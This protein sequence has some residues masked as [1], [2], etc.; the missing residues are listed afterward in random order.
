MFPLLLI[1]YSTITKVLQLLIKYNY[2]SN[3]NYEN[4]GLTYF[5]LKSH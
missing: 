5:S 1:K 3:R 2:Y 4:G